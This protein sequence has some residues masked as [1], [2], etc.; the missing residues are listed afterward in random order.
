[1]SW[2]PANETHAIETMVLEV[3][4]S[5]PFT[6]NDLTKIINEF[7]D[8]KIASDFNSFPIMGFEAHIYESPRFKSVS[9]DVSN[10]GTLYRR[11]VDN[12]INEE[13]GLHILR[14]HYLTNKY[15]SWSLTK[16]R[17][18]ETMWPMIS[19]SKKSNHI[20]NVR[21]IYLNKFEYTGNQN[22]G[23]FSLL[24]DDIQAIIPRKT[25]ANPVNWSHDLS[26]NE[27]NQSEPLSVNQIIEF[28]NNFES[29]QDKNSQ[30]SINL[31][32][33]QSFQNLTIDNKENFINIL[34]KLYTQSVNNLTTSLSVE[35]QKLIGLNQ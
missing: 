19:S 7:Q 4:F 31:N 14:F 3:N 1:M 2:L 8:E 34:E 21:M 11:S 9:R 33:N 10:D 15:I 27:E 26:W 18:I 22:Q 35:G 5:E 28:N 24:S 12:S 30:I 16:E 23:N 29:K 20:E 6:K 17:I 13:I 25:L 32:V